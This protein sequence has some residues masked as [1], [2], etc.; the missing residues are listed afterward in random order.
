MSNVL[1]LDTAHEKNTTRTMPFFS[2]QQQ[3]TNVFSQTFS[4]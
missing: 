3:G 1:L 2:V 4:A